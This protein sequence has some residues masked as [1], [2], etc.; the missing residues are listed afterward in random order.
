MVSAVKGDAETG[1]DIKIVWRI[2]RVTLRACRVSILMN[3]RGLAQKSV[4][5]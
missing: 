1:V 5:P 2:A 4:L 3:W